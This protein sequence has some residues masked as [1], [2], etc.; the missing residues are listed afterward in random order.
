MG[1]PVFKVHAKF[2]MRRPYVLY[3]SAHLRGRPGGVQEGDEPL[4]AFSDNLI[5]SPSRNLRCR[6]GNSGGELCAAVQLDALAG[7]NH[8]NFVG[9]F[10]VTVGAKCQ[11]VRQQSRTRFLISVR[12][13]VNVRRNAA[14]EATQPRRRRAPSESSKHSDSSTCQSGGSKRLEV[15]FT[16]P[17]KV[18]MEMGGALLQPSTRGRSATFLRCCES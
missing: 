17:E 16:K 11:D 18:R 2:M 14:R 3:T 5:F 9:V 15:K 8:F 6:N 12:A 7:T 13:G 4:A 1:G 10:G